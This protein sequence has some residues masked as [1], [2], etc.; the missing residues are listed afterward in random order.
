MILV[1][2]IDILSGKA[3]RLKK[4][5]Y[6]Q[7]TV[8]N[9]DPVAQARAFE[10][11]GAKR[12]H[13]V[14]LD[15]ARDAAPT[16]IDIIARIARQ[17]GVQV[18]VGGG[19]RTRETFERY[20]DA[21]ATRLVLGSALVRDPELAQELAAQYADNV[22]A[23]IDAKDG[24]VA[25]EGW[26]EGTSTPASELVAELKSYGIHELVYTDISRDGM[27]CGIDAAAYARISQAAGFAVTASGGIATLDDIRAL[28]ALPAG[29]IDGVITG[30]AIYE[31][32]FTVEEGV[33]ACE[34]GTA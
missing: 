5:D 1:P 17:T 6:T 33:A 12:I 7:V 34:E 32:A 8:Y 9:D 21:G 30:R 18:E 4:G 23:G 3:V 15:G 31:G 29:S 11:A 10:E 24:M 19:I 2:A 13:I 27:Q 25:V 16:N 26:R 28:V 20:L 14:D 22:V